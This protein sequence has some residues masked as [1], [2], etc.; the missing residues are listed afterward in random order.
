M[1]ISQGSVKISQP[2]H[3]QNRI[4]SVTITPQTQSDH[5]ASYFKT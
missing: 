5:V 1:F 4:N 2:C 3:T